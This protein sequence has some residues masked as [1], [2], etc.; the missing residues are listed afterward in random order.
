MKEN[1]SLILGRLELLNLNCRKDSIKI[2]I[3][4]NIR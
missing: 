1:I 4:K 2:F 3:D